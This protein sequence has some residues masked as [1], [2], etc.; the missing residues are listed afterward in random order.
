MFNQCEALYACSGVAQIP[1]NSK[2]AF[3]YH[4]KMTHYRL[5]ELVKYKN[6]DSEYLLELEEFA[7]LDVDRR[8]KE[9]VVKNY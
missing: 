4:F 6:F 5:L 2:P 3:K 7:D 9:F 8:W 1:C